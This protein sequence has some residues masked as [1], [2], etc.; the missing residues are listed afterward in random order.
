[1][2]NTNKHSGWCKRK[3]AEG[4][5][6]WQGKSLEREEEQWRI[7]LSKDEIIEVEQAL[8]HARDSGCRSITDMSDDPSEFPLQGLAEKLSSIGEQLKNGLGFAVLGGLPIG[9]YES[10]E[11]AIMLRGISSYL[12]VCVSQ[13]YRGDLIGQVIDRSDEIPDPRR[14]EAGG[15]FRMHIDPIDIVGLMCIRKAKQGGE[16]E[17]VSALAVHN[18]LLDERPDLLAILYDGFYLFRPHPDRGDAPALTAE[19]VPF[20]AADGDGG[21]ASYFLPDPVIQAVDRKFVT[22]STPEREALDYAEKIAARAELVLSMQLVPGDI[23]FLNNRKILHRRAAY[24]DFPEKERRRLMLR[25]WMMNA[26]WSPR[27]PQQRFF[28]QSHRAGGGIVPQLKEND[29]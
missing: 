20:F 22:L 2:E 3:R 27:S 18:T 19:K 24:E 12:G 1:M 17:I 9:K 8:L 25:I 29:S 7:N 14:Y 11:I 13:N 4:K 5:A 15:E 21:F 10:Q 28:D 16:S 23:Q 26:K 6:L